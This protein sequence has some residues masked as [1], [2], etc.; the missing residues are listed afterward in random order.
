MQIE[1]IVE[2]YCNPQ[3]TLF[4]AI[5]FSIEAEERVRNQ[6]RS[7]I[8][9]DLTWLHEIMYLDKNRKWVYSELYTVDGDF[10]KRDSPWKFD[11]NKNKYTAGCIPEGGLL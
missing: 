7:L 11:N 5:E 1:F 10:I 3:Q 2:K 8:N 4:Q 9:K 6:Y